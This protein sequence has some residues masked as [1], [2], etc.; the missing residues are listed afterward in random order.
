[1][2]LETLLVHSGG[3]TDEGTGAVAPPLHLS[4]TFEHG[5]AGEMPRGYQ[6]ARTENPTQ[7]RLET[8]LAAVEGGER[9]FFFASGMAAGAAVLQTLPRGSHVLFP[10]DAYHGF[11]ELIHDFLPRWDCSATAVDFSDLDAVQGALRPE[12]RLLWAET[13]SNPL[14]K[15]T[16]L[17]AVAEIARGAGA[18]MLVDSTFA[19]PVI[20]RPLELGTDIVLHSAT[21]YFGGHSDV[22]GGALVLRRR[23]PLEEVLTS[24]RTTLGA[25]ASPFNAWLVL[26]GLRSLACRVER[27]CSNALA[28]AEALAEHPAVERVHYPG[29]AGHPGHL[30]ARRQM[31]AYGGMLSLRIRGG[32]SQSGREAALAVAGRLKLFVN[33]TS[34][35]GVESLVEHR[36]SIEG[37]ESTTPQNL[38][39]LSIGLEHP[40][41]LIAD[42]RQA[43][44]GA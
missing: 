12:T 7:D 19:P 28:I 1:M 8:A 6:Y 13:P 29:L 44:E 18:L 26:R 31:R 20:Q 43:L 35:G 16:D 38:L 24:V 39:R 32:P 23:K 5:P 30:V 22:V 11:Q 3:E 40:D 21:K 4:T 14:L 10:D 36:A 9:G 25:V 37:A 27:H 2:R 17:A 41:D 15:I 33:A 42:F 34:L